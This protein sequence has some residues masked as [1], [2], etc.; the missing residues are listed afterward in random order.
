MSSEDYPSSAM[1]RTNLSSSSNRPNIT[2]P[3]QDQNFPDG[4]PP[5][6]YQYESRPADSDT[7]PWQCCVCGPS[8]ANL[9][10]VGHATPASVFHP[11]NCKQCRHSVCRQC[12]VEKSF[13]AVPQEIHDQIKRVWISTVISSRKPNIFVRASAHLWARLGKKEDE[14]KADMKCTCCRERFSEFWA[15][16]RNKN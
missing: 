10:R 4:P 8:I 11:A 1:P 15:T 6:Y 2:L 16:F 9:L 5:D 7:I 13:Q 14:T 12:H 3:S